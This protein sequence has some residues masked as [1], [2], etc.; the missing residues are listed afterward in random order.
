MPFALAQDWS[1]L[2]GHARDRPAP[3]GPLGLVRRGRARSASALLL[4]FLLGATTLAAYLS[5]GIEAS[6][7]SVYFLILALGALLWEANAVVA[8]AAFSILALW[9]LLYLQLRT[10][11]L[12]RSLPFSASWVLLTSLILAATAIVLY[13]ALQR[14]LTALERAH[15]NEQALAESNR[16][17]EQEVA[18][19]RQAESSCNSAQPNWKPCGSSA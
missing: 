6:I 17:F 13:F 9:G 15:R 19:R 1:S 10:G 16:Q 18:E 2:A 14:F 12:V 7:V 5:G 11:T 8:L 4:P 3:A